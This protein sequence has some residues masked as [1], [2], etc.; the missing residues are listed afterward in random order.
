MTAIFGGLSCL[1]SFYQVDQQLVVDVVPRS[2]TDTSA[3]EE[4]ELAQVMPLVN[5]S[6]ISLSGTH[7]VFVC[8]STAYARGCVGLTRS[9][10]IQVPLSK[11]DLLLLAADGAIRPVHVKKYAAAQ[12]GGLRTKLI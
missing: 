2:Y 4:A 6:S 1:P 8:L 10:V 7:F 3:I 11:D 5:P 9:L 12:T